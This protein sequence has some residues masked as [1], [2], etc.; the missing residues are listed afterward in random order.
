MI[1]T[2]LRKSTEAADT[3]RSLAADTEAAAGKAAAAADT[4]QAQRRRLAAHADSLASAAEDKQ[5][6][7]ADVP[8][9]TLLH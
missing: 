9:D 6:D 3:A 4:E 2:E 7:T 8:E 5:L 1:N